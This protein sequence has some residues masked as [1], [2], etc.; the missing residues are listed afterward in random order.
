[1]TTFKTVASIL[2]IALLQ[3]CASGGGIMDAPKQNEFKWN[4]NHSTALNIIKAIDVDY[5][6]E[7]RELPEDL[8]NEVRSSGLSEAVF[9]IGDGLSYSSS[10]HTLGHLSDLG[11]LG[12]GFV[13]FM[14]STPEVMKFDDYYAFWLPY[15]SGQTLGDHIPFITDEIT[16]SYSNLE[17]NV[18]GKRVDPWSVEGMSMQSIYHYT[19]GKGEPDSVRLLVDLKNHGIVNGSDAPSHLQN[20]S[21]KY[22]LAVAQISK[23]MKASNVMAVGLSNNTFLF[24]YFGERS[25]TKQKIFTDP[26]VI[27]QG[28]EYRF[29]KPIK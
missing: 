17:D 26:R 5:V 7:D 11:A 19:N 6:K 8:K 16:K 21:E 28:I 2:T 29:I 14:T 18:S 24:A 15:Q 12:L 20:K 25:S 9:A 1:M 10:V 3:A 13:S 23:G 4:P 27:N 22:L